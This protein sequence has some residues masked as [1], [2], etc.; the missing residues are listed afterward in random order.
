MKRVLTAVACIL[1]LLI[2]TALLVPSLR[3]TI[4][5][6]AM[7]AAG[8]PLDEASAQIPRVGKYK[9]YTLD[10]PVFD[11]LIY[12]FDGA[13]RNTP[14]EVANAGLRAIR[15]G[16]FKH[17]KKMTLVIFCNLT[18]A[19]K[20]S[21]AV[22]PFGL[23][24]ESDAIRN[25]RVPVEDLARQPIVMHPMTW[26]GRINEWV[27]AT[28]SL[29]KSGPDVTENPDYVRFTNALEPG[30]FMGLDNLTNKAEVYAKFGVPRYYVRELGTYSEIYPVDDAER[31]QAGTARVWYDADRVTKA[32]CYMTN[33]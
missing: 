17:T 8:I 5:F 28:N 30:W 18:A 12:H 6:R 29:T 14:A 3:R 21:E 15:R 27:Y 9:E 1:C 2:G 33:K 20:S 19:S 25:R 10:D 13:S 11:Y 7:M 24:L 31:G 26:D 16:G 22:Y 4:L 23:F 32:G